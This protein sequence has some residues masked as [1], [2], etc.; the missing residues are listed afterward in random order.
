MLQLIII[1]WLSLFHPFYVSVTE[2]N[3]NARSQEVEISCRIFYDDLERTLE[4]Q[5]HTHVD[6]VKPADKTKMNQLLNDYIKKHLIVKADGKQLA[7]SYV[8]YEIQEDA[9]W[10]YFE[11]KGINKVK[12]FEVHDD[13]LFTEHPEQINMLHVT[14]GGQ[15]KSTKLSNPE[16]D[17]AFEF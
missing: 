15:R 5:Y 17:A 2:I 14:V 16:S 9:A 6:I 4:K 3:H 8:G 12:K 1:S 7:L 10:T 11:V 13:L